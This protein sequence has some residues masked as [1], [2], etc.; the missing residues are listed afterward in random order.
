[1]HSRPANH[2]PHHFCRLSARLRSERA[3]V[4]TFSGVAKSTDLRLE[5]AALHT[6][7]F[8]HASDVSISPP[9]LCGLL[10]VLPLPR[11]TPTAY[12]SCNYET[13]DVQVTLGDRTLSLEPITCFGNPL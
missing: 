4:L 7:V 6:S 5:I 9:L 13:L 2:P 11:A 8:L 3:C 1:M 10:A 12:P